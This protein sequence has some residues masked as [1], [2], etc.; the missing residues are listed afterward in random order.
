MRRGPIKKRIIEPDL[1]YSSTL[2]SRLIN[3]IMQEG[4]KDIARKVVYGAMELAEKKLGKPAL[5]IMEQ[6]IN[7]TGP[8]ME[9]KSKRI[10]GA[11]YQVPHEV[12]GERKV[13]L[14]FR[15]L[16]EAAHNR[17]GKPMDQKLGE[18]LIEA[19]NNQGSAVKKKLDTHKMAEANKA[20]AHFA[21]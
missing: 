15:W 10:G 4:K 20:F 14:A 17:K 13:I 1:K 5:E 9:L 8:Q 7:N 16:I 6:A 2:V 19:F 11:N 18:E 3:Y 21:W 12:K